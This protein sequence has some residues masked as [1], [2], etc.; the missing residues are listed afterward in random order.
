[1]MSSRYV[2]RIV[3]EEHCTT[4]ATKFLSIRSL[5]IQ[6]VKTWWRIA[7]LSTHQIGKF[8]SSFAMLQL[9]KCCSMVI[10]AWFLKALIVTTI[11]QFLNQRNPCSLQLRIGL[12]L[13]K[14][15]SVLNTEPINCCDIC[16][17]QGTSPRR[18]VLIYYGLAVEKR[19]L[20]V[21]ISS[22]FDLMELELDSAY[23]IQQIVKN[24]L[25]HPK[26]LPPLPQSI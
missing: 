9:A 23:Q 6:L 22:F 8:N 25:R 24:N 21:E 13:V 18:L 4:I 10:Q 3:D 26:R 17:M 19:N 2:M 12:N 14:F 15:S 20:K 16:I 11:K 5:A 1:M 7:F